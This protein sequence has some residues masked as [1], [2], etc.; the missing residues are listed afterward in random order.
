M[1]EAKVNGGANVN[2]K[3]L[4]SFGGNANFPSIRSDFHLFWDFVDASTS[5]GVDQFWREPEIV[6]FNNVQL[7]LGEF[8]TNFAAPVLNTVQ[9]LLGPFQSVIDILVDPIP[10]ISDLAGNLSH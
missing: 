2:L 8:F 5:G 6:E 4:A 7:S 9:D 1:I 10:L 3:L